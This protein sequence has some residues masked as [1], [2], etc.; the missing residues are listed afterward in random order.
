MMLKFWLSQRTLKNGRKCWTD[1]GIEELQ[2]Q[3]RGLMSGTGLLKPVCEEGSVVTCSTMAFKP[4]EDNAGS[5]RTRVLSLA[6]MSESGL[7]T[8]IPKCLEAADC[9]ENLFLH[10]FWRSLQKIRDFVRNRGI[11][12]PEQLPIKWCVGEMKQT[13]CP[14]MALKVPFPPRSDTWWILGLFTVETIWH[15][16]ELMFIL[17]HVG[18][19]WYLFLFSSLEN[20]C[21]VVDEPTIIKLYI[22][23]TVHGVIWPHVSAFTS[24]YWVKI[25]SHVTQ[26]AFCM[27]VIHQ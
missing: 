16:W 20:Y 22:L 14:L 4:V 24:S 1:S 11:T 3:Y 25:S 2:T 9:E 19:L 6:T 27:S 5:G 12:V 21:H 15:R 8:D 23:W 17:L 18:D 7:S 10:H 26:R 13:F